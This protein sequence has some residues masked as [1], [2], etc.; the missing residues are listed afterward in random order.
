MRKLLLCFV[1]LSGSTFAA[2]VINTQVDCPVVSGEGAAGCTANAGEYFA[3]VFVYPGAN[4]YGSASASFS[5]EYVLT[6]IAGPEQGFIGACFYGS[7]DTYQGSDYADGGFAGLGVASTMRA[8]NFDT[9][10]QSG[11][12]NGEL[13]SYTLGVP[14]TS[15][16]GLSASVSTS[17]AT[18]QAQASANFTGFVF[19]DAS[20]NPASGVNYSFDEV[21]GPAVPSL[22]RHSCCF[23]RYCCWCG[24]RRYAKINWALTASR[25]GA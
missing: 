11:G 21:P 24:A 2:P 5:D 4:H 15:F 3:S 19:F 9:C 7:G 13:M 8:F 25:L 17:G 22:R 18:P 6:V 23:A 1:L 12:Y 14:I 10:P 20:M 16:L